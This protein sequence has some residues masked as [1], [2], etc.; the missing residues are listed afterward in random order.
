[1]IT[2]R[3]LGPPEV[4]VDGQQAPADL[5]WRK[6]L[7]LLVYLA[8]SP[9]RSRT[10]EHLIGLLWADKPQQ[11]AGHSLREAIRV[12]RRYVGEGVVDAGGD[13]VRLSPDGVALDV[14]QF[15]AAASR[16]DWITA[17]TLVAGEF[18]E[19]F[20][21][22][23]ASA[24]E[25]WIASERLALRQ[26][27]V[28]AL[29]RCA[30]ERLHQGD[31]TLATREALRALALDP[32]SEAAVS[33][34]MR[35]LALSGE[36]AA[37]LEQFMAFTARL[38]EATG[39]EPTAA[40]S[41]LAERVQRERAW[42]LPDYLTTD[43]GERGTRQGADSRRAPLCGRGTELRALADAWAS[44]R[45][46]GRFGL[47]LITGDPGVGKTRLLEELLGR[48]R[49]DGAS[50]STALAVPAD[51]EQKHSGILALARGGLLTAPGV[52]GAPPAA[53]AALSAE[54][55][56]WAERFAQAAPGVERQPLGRAL[57][58]VVRAAAEESPVVLA[59]DDA[60]SL[61]ASSLEVIPALARNLA[62]RPVLIALTAERHGVAALDALWARIG[63]E[64]EGA[65]VEL[66]P[67]DLAA[68]RDLAHWALPTYDESELDRLARRV[69]ADSA[70]LPLLAVELLHAVAVGLDLGT[71]SG[72]WPQ[73]QRTL[74]Q[75]MPGDL[76]GAVVAALRVGF[77]RLSE[78][79]QRALSAAAVLGAR[80]DASTIGRGADL[81]GEPLARALDE[82]EWQRWLTAD[83]R[84]YTFL[85]RVV[86]EVL[87]REMVLPGQR[88]RILA[89]ARGKP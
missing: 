65:S 60:H 16:G 19:G 59:V 53:L 22:P 1:M 33:T 15:Q 28:E 41:A 63:R 37:A 48:T 52:G 75:T 29:S 66:R 49:L 56:E 21:V 85:A 62:D 8:R 55:P 14:D 88:E 71:V 25:D 13:Q 24:F 30:E 58:E 70:G 82:L 2:C 3:T 64:V 20:S 12:L 36:R 4:L 72:A 31:A 57:G 46:R 79:A 80:V 17:A 76:P 78:Q 67:L 35:A 7:A 51:R 26:Q 74:D 34:A 84:G 61:D 32:L 86:R 27:S 9:K 54:L 83:A 87:A 38:R 11:R 81:T 5:L 44:V 47:V 39:T 89:R 69:S 73:P 23:D 18:L 40:L 50:L 77:R 6:N 43:R 68:M 45:S 10:R 42:R